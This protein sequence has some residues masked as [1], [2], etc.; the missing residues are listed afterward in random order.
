MTM[1]ERWIAVQLS[2]IGTMLMTPFTAPH[3]AVSTPEAITWGQCPRVTEG[4]PDVGRYSVCDVMRSSALIA[5]D[6]RE[7]SV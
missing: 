2:L 5:P 3:A 4:F 6:M 1:R 7:F